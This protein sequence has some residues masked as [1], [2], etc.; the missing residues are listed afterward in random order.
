MSYRPTIVAAAVAAAADVALRGPEHVG[1][2]PS[3][4]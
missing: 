3:A 1:L 4:P 2:L